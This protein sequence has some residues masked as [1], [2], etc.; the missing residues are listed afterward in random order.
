MA[1]MEDIFRDSG[2]HS[3][4][5]ALLGGV[6]WSELTTK[7]TPGCECSLCAYCL[8]YNALTRLRGNPTPLPSIVRQVSVE[9]TSTK[10]TFMM[11]VDDKVTMN[12][13]FLSPVDP[14]D[15]QRQSMPVSYMNVAVASADGNLHRVSVYTDIT[16]EWTSGDRNEV[17]EWSRGVSQVSGASG[18]GD[19]AFHKVWRQNQIEFAEKN[20]QAAWGYWYYVTEN[21]A[22]LTYGSGSDA[23]I[24][25]QFITNGSLDN[26]DD[27]KFRAINDKY[28][29]FA[30]AL[31]LGAVAQEPVEALFSINLLQSN[32]IQFAT[33]PGNIKKIA[34]FWTNF[35]GNELSAITTFFYDYTTAMQ[36]SA[37]LDSTVASDARA[38]A[39]D[40]YVA[41]V[42]LAVRQAWGGVQIAGTTAKNYMFLKEISSDGNIQ[43]V[44]VIF[45]FHPMLLYMN[46]DWMKLLLDPLFI[47]EESG[48]WPKDFAIHDLGTHYPNATGHPDGKAALQPLEECG[49]M[50]IMSLAYAQRT[51]D[52]EYLNQHWDSLHKW[53]Q[54]LITNDSVIPFDQISTGA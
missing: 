54:W 28:P 37:A 22:G 47:N 9:Y 35:A 7:P 40:D 17:V 53:G 14:K 39:G 45:P 20:D 43:T 25:S 33:S 42:S 16:A 41:I 8:L 12:I 4:L 24:R 5:A 1:E 49:N 51:G 18:T 34:S 10:T 29:C 27:V 26:S 6:E 3:G 23:D 46:A 15:K 13:T 44:D 31:D 48:L 21:K 32:A 11:N 19:L 2:P 36:V 50:L 38:A 52:T 30:F